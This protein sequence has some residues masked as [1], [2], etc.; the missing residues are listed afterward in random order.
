MVGISAAVN[1]NYLFI[2]N[3]SFLLFHTFVKAVLQGICSWI[4]KIVDCKYKGF[5]K[6]AY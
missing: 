4:S 3:N 6:Q 1:S 5:P 2:L